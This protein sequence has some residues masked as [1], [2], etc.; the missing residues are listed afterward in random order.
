MA[1]NH[2]APLNILK[3]IFRLI[4]KRMVLLLKFKSIISIFRIWKR[5][6][7]QRLEKKNLLLEFQNKLKIKAMNT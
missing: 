2:E 5:V 6:K 1:I 4:D 7:R 3:K